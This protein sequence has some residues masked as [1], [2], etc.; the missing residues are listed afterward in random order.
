[1]L[2]GLVRKWR[3]SEVGVE[4]TDRLESAILALA[5]FRH[6]VDPQAREDVEH[7]IEQVDAVRRRVHMHVVAYGHPAYVRA[8]ERKRG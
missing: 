6:T 4:T 8:V 7:L 3:C 2:P 1:M 5:E